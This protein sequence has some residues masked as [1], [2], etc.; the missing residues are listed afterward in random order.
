VTAYL[1]GGTD[2]MGVTVDKNKPKALSEEF[3]T[4]LKNSTYL[5][6]YVP[7][8]NQ[9]LES[10]PKGSLPNTEHTLFW[11]KDT[12]GLKPV[13]SMYHATIHKPED[14]RAGLLVAMKTLYASHYFNAALE[15]MAAVPTP[16]AATKPAF[17]LLDLYRA[18][19]DPPTGMLSGVLMGKVK[20]GIERGVAMNLKNAKARVEAK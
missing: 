18:R 12:F 13:V 10:Y 16:D 19:I 20:G 14:A 15:I 4:L 7:A 17:Y 6:E 8:F 5:V 3:R 1:A 11:T 2:A 9:Y